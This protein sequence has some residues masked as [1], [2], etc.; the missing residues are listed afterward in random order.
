MLKYHKTVK[1]TMRFIRHSSSL[2]NQQPKD[3]RMVK[4]LSWW[5]TPKGQRTAG[6]LVIGASVGSAFFHLAPHSFL[7]NVIRD[8][9]QYHRTGLPVRVNDNMKRLLAEIQSEVNLTE[10]EV[11]SN[12]FFVLSKLDTNSWGDLGERCIVGYPFFFHYSTASDAPIASMTFGRQSESDVRSLT[13]EALESTDAKAL[14]ESM[15]LSNDARKFAI[16]REIFSARSGYHYRIAV[17]NSTIILL[18][19]FIA[20]ALNKRF[21]LRQIERVLLYTGIAIAL[22]LLYWTVKDIDNRRFQTKLD[23]S[24]AGL[25]LSYAL[26]GVEYYD[27]ILARNRALR[28]LSWN[29]QKLYNT[30]GEETFEWIRRRNQLFSDRKKNCLEISKKFN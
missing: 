25:S 30:R 16:A 8:L 4:F 9:H 3:T 7:L 26:G 14:A 23:E 15:V 6:F 19:L 2:N 20:R 13:Q 12:T 1:Q 21:R 22:S 27:K 24:V 18:G 29:G 17:F 11:A 5:T 28:T 10:E